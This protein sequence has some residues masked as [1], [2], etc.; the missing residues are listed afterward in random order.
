MN[1]PGCNEPLHGLGTR[2]WAGGEGCGWVL[3]KDEPVPEGG[4]TNATKR[5]PDPR[6][7]KS[8]QAAIKLAW[9]ALGYEVWNVS[10]S[11]ATNQALGLPDQF[12]VGNGRIIWNE[13]KRPQGK[14]SQHQK[15]VERLVTEN[16]GIYLITRH[17][18]EVLA[19]HQEAA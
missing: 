15:H 13:I 17:E 7:E 19:W 6:L 16:G 12:V 4:T 18:S 14:Q 3:G 8:I 2:C 5:P 10:Q 11:R 1:C 9:E